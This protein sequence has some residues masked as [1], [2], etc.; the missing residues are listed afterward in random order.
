MSFVELRLITSLL[1]CVMQVFGSKEWLLFPPEAAHK[2]R[3]SRVP[4][5]ESSVYSSCTQSE[6]KMLAEDPTK[7]AIKV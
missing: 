7:K 1:S 2:L 4:Y 6:L 3:P 5:E